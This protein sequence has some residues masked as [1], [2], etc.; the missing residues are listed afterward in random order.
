LQ[1]ITENV[2]R[3]SFLEQE[4]VGIYFW[5]WIKKNRGQHAARVPHVVSPPG[6]YLRIK[7]AVT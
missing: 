5:E 4:I 3:I 1:S 7:Y 2:D 6:K